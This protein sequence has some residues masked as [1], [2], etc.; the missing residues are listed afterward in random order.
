MKIVSLTGVGTGVNYVAE[1]LAENSD[2]VYLKPYTDKP[3]LSSAENLMD[4][5]QISKDE[6]DIMIQNESVLCM[7]KINGHRWV[8]FEF[9]L[10]EAYNILITDDYSL[11]DLR[12]N[13]GGDLYTVKVATEENLKSKRIGVYL[14]NH[15]FDE[16]FDYK[17]DDIDEL[18]A[19]IV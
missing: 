9:Q 6:M 17:T 3:K 11:V 1:K 2:V 12:D 19:R 7:T 15:E 10:K 4:Y 5:H 13:Y 16:V 8:Y 14:Y 18:G